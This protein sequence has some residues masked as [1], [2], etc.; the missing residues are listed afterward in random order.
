MNRDSKTQKRKYITRAW[1][2]RPKVVG[3]KSVK[4]QNCVLGSLACITEEKLERTLERSRWSWVSMP[5]IHLVKNSYNLHDISSSPSLSLSLSLCLSLPPPSS[6]LSFSWLYLIPFSMVSL[7]H[8]LKLLYKPPL[9]WSPMITPLSTPFLFSN[10]F[11][12]SP[13]STF[14][15]IVD[16]LLFNP[17]FLFLSTVMREPRFHVAMFFREG[18][19]LPKPQEQALIGLSQFRYSVSYVSD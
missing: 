7:S 14:K 8:V 5:S 1:S 12:F 10:T 6:F 2:R 18:I 15:K 11:K 9:K 4:R 19:T 16:C 17:S 13:E 3:S